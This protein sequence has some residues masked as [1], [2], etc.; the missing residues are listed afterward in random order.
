MEITTG[1]LREM[2]ARRDPEHEHDYG[3]D[4]FDPWSLFLSIF[5]NYD[6]EFD[7][8]AIQVL[9]EI[10]TSKRGPEPYPLSH[11]MFRE[12][13]C[14]T[15]LCDYGTSPRVCFPLTEEHRGL[16]VQLR[17]R[18]VTHHAVRWPDHP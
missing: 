5:G 1:M 7:A 11:D 8:M 13:L 17:D 12:M 3:D 18:W 16:L 4:V 10:V 6:S 14:A 15:G 9:T 2:L